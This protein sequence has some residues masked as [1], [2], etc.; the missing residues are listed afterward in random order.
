MSKQ[1][2]CRPSLCIDLKKNRIRIHR[3]TLQMIGSPEYIQLL[4]N[5]L[6]SMIA[7]KGSIHKDHLAHKIHLDAADCIELYS[8]GLIENLMTV[9]SDLSLNKSYRLYGCLDTKKGIALFPMHE[10][11]P[12]NAVEES[13]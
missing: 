3:H 10:P 1:T 12:L 5:P 6:A 8:S 4:V 9:N 11:V 7:I 13:Q 2:S